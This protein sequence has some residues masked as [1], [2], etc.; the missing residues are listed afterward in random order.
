[1]SLNAPRELP[2]GDATP[3]LVEYTPVMPQVDLYARN[4]EQSPGAQASAKMN[5]REYDHAPEEELNRILWEEAKGPNV[6]YPTPIHRA[7]F[8]PG[9]TLSVERRVSTWRK[10]L[11]SI[12]IIP[13]HSRHAFVSEGAA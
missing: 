2:G 10:F 11:V 6:P 5:F 4:T 3:Q 8:S 9:G 1:M 13:A 12:G 7:V